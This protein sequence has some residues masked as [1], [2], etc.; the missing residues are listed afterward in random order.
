MRSCNRVLKE[1]LSKKHIGYAWPFY[2][3][4]DARALGLHDY[5]DII[6]HPMD[7][8]TV[9]KK[10][11]GR[12]Y[13]GAP[14][15]AADVRVMFSNCYKYN[16]PDHDVVNMARKLQDVFEMRFAKMPDEPE[17]RTPTPSSALH[18]APSS[19][20]HPAP[21]IRQAPPPPAASED[22][23]P[24]SSES[25]GGDSDHEREH[26][27]VE[28]QEQLKATSKKN[29]GSKEPVVLK[30]ERKKPGKKEGVK[31]SRPLVAPQ[32]GPTPLVPSAALEA[33]DELDVFGAVTAERGKPMSY[34]EK[35]QLSLDINKLPGDKLGRVVHIIQTREPSLKNSN[36]DE[37][38]IDFETLK[39][40][41]LR[42]LEKYVCT[43]LK[44]KKKTSA[45]K[46]LD[47]VAT[48]KAG[49]SSSGSSDSSDSEDS[50]IGL[51][52]KRKLS[53]TRDPKRL[54]PPLHLSTAAPQ[55]QVVQPPPRR[56]PSYPPQRCTSP[57][58]SSRPDRATGRRRSP[59]KPPSPPPPRCP[60]PHPS[61][62]YPSPPR[63]PPPPSPRCTASWELSQLS[64]PQ[65]LL[66]DDDEPP[67]S[68]APT[69]LS[70]VQNFLQSLQPRPLAPP[71]TQ[72][73]V[74]TRQP[75]PHVHAPTQQQ[76]GGGALQQKVQQP[77][78]RGKHTESFSTGC[79]PRES[80]PPPTTSSPQM[81][82]L[83]PMAQQSPPQTK[84]HEQRSN[85]LPVKEEK[86][87]LSPVLPPSPFSPALRQD[88]HKHD[89]KHRFDL[90]PSD[91][92]RLPPRLPP[93]LPDSPAPPQHDVKQ[94][95]KTPIAPKKTQVS[96]RFVRFPPDS[97]SMEPRPLKATRRPVKHTSDLKACSRMEHAPPRLPHL[98][99]AKGIKPSLRASHSTPA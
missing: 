64:H 20:L 57:S 18:P 82:Q 22:S 59:P 29:K 73:H 19:A 6:K 7:L 95:P 76:K 75:P 70:Q 62:R 74:H 4:V 92:S 71:L 1:L 87:S 66:E 63:P 49:S 34:E 14:E 40:S 31:H 36:P 99:F 58:P 32:P 54:H 10:L 26:R 88:S 27:L 65:A 56:I 81:P 47:T 23:S 77:S 93:R 39:P 37:I 69:P 48:T 72:R 8:S 98:H 17:D 78:P 85:M 60:P 2:K 80:P 15:F 89:S 44:K 84:K 16:P 91:G 25:S 38:E 68:E 52:P 94:E 35:R 41:T 97:T 67:P 46:P 96:V 28:L 30:K 11:D 50:D 51:V 90:K 24:S 79:V 83:L 45:E 12:Q 86:P 53:T 55:P 61:P 9:K 21:S 3:P 5:H 43:C 42:E 33:E 13:R